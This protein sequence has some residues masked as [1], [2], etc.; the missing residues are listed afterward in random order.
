MGLDICWPRG[1]ASGWRF[2]ILYKPQDDKLLNTNLTNAVFVNYILS[3]VSRANNFRISQVSRPRWLNPMYVN[4]SVFPICFDI[5]VS[6]TSGQRN[7]LSVFESHVKRGLCADVE[8]RDDQRSKRR[9]VIVTWHLIKMTN[10]RL[11][12]W[13]RRLWQRTTGAVTQVFRR[14]ETAFEDLLF[15]NKAGGHWSF[16]RH[17]SFRQ[18]ANEV[19]AGSLWSSFGAH[20]DTA[21]SQKS[22]YSLKGCRYWMRDSDLTGA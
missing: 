4:P 9:L 21:I 2:P 20:R 7:Q 10:G 14:N 18:E 13:Q 8:P 1:G 11:Q 15:R 22:H 6:V 3:E 16:C 19:V 17:W 12:A 5:F